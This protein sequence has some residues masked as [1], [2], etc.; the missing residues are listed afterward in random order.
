VEIFLGK[1]PNA[2]TIIGTVLTISSCGLI[3]LKKIQEDNRESQLKSKEGSSNTEQTKQNEIIKE[4][5]LYPIKSD[6]DNE[7]E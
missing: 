4:E 5:E 1:T 2:V 6:K 7:S 3:A